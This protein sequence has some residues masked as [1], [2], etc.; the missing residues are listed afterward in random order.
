MTPGALAE[1]Q[2]D[3]TS[4]KRFL[5]MVGGGTAATGLA[6]LLA[7]CG[8]KGE[9]EPAP[10][11]KTAGSAQEGGDIGILNYALTLEHLETAFYEQAVASG[12]LKDRKALELA[13]AF[14]ATEAE[15]VEAITA[16]IKR[17]GGEPVPAPNT[18][19]E[20]VFRD[21]QESIIQ[22]AAT[23]ENLGAAAYL[24]AAPLIE[25]KEV[26]AAALSIHSV[27]AR[28]AAALNKL[29]GRPFRGGGPLEGMVPDGPFAKPMSMDQVLAAAKPFIGS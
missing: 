17:M 28:H 23:V 6:A 4:R 24:G 22:I 20:V 8:E 26:L 1:L 25:S 19:F 9:P 21:G 11:A 5:R 3:D 16:T 18:A 27:E 7:A 15:H 10:R 29:A 2:Q 13:K 14:G 12:V